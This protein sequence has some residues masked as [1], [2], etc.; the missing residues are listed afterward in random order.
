LGASWLKAANVFCFYVSL[1]TFA[2]VFGGEHY[3]I[4]AILGLGYALAV[5]FGS[6]IWESRRSESRKMLSKAGTKTH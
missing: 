2:L 5:E 1:M 4:D 6:Q 3:I